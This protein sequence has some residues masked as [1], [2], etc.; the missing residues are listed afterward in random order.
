[1]EFSR[2]NPTT[3]QVV[4]TDDTPSWVFGEGYGYWTSTANTDKTSEVWRV[5]PGGYVGS[6]GVYYGTFRGVRPV[7]T[8]S[9]SAISA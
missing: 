4:Q 8:I 9:K 6:Y 5:D 3:M 1:M 2:P 7:I